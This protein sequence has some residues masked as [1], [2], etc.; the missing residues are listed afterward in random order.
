MF[1]RVV[2]YAAIAADEDPPGLALAMLLARCE[3]LLSGVGEASLLD[4]NENEVNGSTT[5]W[6]GVGMGVG[7]PVFEAVRLFVLAD[8]GEARRESVLRKVDL[9]LGGAGRDSG[10]MGRVGIL[11]LG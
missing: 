11:M 6:P 7:S 2:R 4:E 3:L 5:S 9:R 1:D 8:V 10:L